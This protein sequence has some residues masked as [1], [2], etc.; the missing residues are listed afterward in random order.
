M[1]S[2]AALF[3][4]VILPA[5]AVAAQDPWPVSVG[6]GGGMLTN[7]TPH[8]MV[9]V[10]VRPTN[11]LP[12][13]LRLDGIWRPAD[14]RINADLLSA[15]SASAIV[16]L[17]PW[18]FAPYL[19]VGA[20]RTSEYVYDLGLTGPAYYTSPAVTQLTGGIG[21]ETRLRRGRAFLELRELRN[22]GIPLSLGFS[23]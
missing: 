4:C 6:L 7:N 2:L 18:R 14:G 10:G 16:T 9:L 20:T 8:A 3:F 23:F 19:I 12:V 17:R 21:F 1:R 5:S 13:S 15:V 22:S 11:R